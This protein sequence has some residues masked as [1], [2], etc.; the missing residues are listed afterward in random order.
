LADQSLRGSEAVVL[1][2][3]PEGIVV[4]RSAFYPGGGGRSA[5]HRSSALERALLAYAK[6]MIST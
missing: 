6:A 4:N 3:T 5:D 2:S 1:D